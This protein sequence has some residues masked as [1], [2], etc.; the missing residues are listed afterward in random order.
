MKNNRKVAKSDILFFRIDFIV[1]LEEIIKKLA[2]KHNVTEQ[3]ARQVLFNNPR[4]RFAENGYVAGDDVYAA[5]GQ[6]FAGRYLSKFFVYKP[7]NKTA[8]IISSRDMSQKER[9]VYGRK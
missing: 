2:T 6:T 4:I 8:V 9:K 7:G 1:C 3:E 5:F